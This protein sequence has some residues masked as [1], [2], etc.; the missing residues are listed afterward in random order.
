M[1]RSPEKIA[2]ATAY[3]VQSLI[4]TAVTAI[5]TGELLSGHATDRSETSFLKDHCPE[6][7]KL[8]LAERA[9]KRLAGEVEHGDPVEVE[10][11]EDALAVP[12]LLKSMGE[13]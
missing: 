13:N 9:A 2:P 11:L 7:M 3:E 8:E 6:W 1:S 10:V 5:K 12:R 4:N